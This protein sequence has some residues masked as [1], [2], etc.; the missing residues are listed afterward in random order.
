MLQFAGKRITVKKL[1]LHTRPDYIVYDDGG[2]LPAFT[3][4]RAISSLL[5]SPPRIFNVH[6]FNYMIAPYCEGPHVVAFLENE[7]NVVRLTDTL[8]YLGSHIDLFA[9]SLPQGLER[10]GGDLSVIRFEAD[11]FGVVSLSF[12]ILLTMS[13]LSK[14]PR[15]QR[16]TEQVSD[17]N[18]LEDWLNTLGENVNPRDYQ[19]VLSP[20]MEPASFYLRRGGLN[21]KTMENYDI[22][23]NSLIIY[24]GLDMM[25]MRKVI[26]MFSR[27]IKVK[28]ML[29]DTD[30]LL[31]PLYLTL[32]MGA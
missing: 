18:D 1:E 20:I 17:L 25:I 11:K 22:L 28:E 6:E 7:D 19:V 5:Y 9:S 4:A 13:G 8:R 2:S 21:V 16:I 15:T 32:K 31:A 23:V 24:N 26:N 30:P 27:D 14:T 12:S 3:Y 10:K 29:I